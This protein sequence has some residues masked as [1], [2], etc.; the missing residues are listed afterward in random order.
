MELKA[1]AAKPQLELVTVDDPVIVE[2]YGEPLEFYMWDRQDIPTYL[3]LSQ[4]KDDQLAIFD[5]VKTIVLDQAGQPVLGPGD[6]LPIEIMIP[7]IKAAVAK[8]GNKK[9]LTSAT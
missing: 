9:P 5:I 7:V 1:L 4:I 2:A 6:V 3:K 8:L